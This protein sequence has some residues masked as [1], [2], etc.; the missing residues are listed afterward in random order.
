LS[1][2]G[3]PGPVNGLTDVAGLQVGHWQEDQAPY[4]TGTTVVLAL[5]GAVAGVDVRGG[6]PGTRET[7]ALDPR[8]LVGQAHAVVLTGGSAYGLDAASGVMAWLDERGTG[9]PVGPE[10]GQVVPIVPAAVLFDLGR[11][12]AWSARPDATFGYRAAARASAGPVAAGC[13]G[14]GT[15]AVAGGIKGGSGTASTVLADG[16]VVAAIVAVNA[17]GSGIDPVTGLPWALDHGLEGE[18]GSLL[19]PAEAER[20]EL[21]AAT[22]EGRQGRTGQHTTIGVVAT[23]ATLTGPEASKLAGVAHDGL[24]RALRPAHGPLDGDTLFA[25]STGRRELGA[26]P[27]TTEPV[28]WGGPRAVRLERVYEA[29]AGCV[30]RAVVHALLAARGAGGVPSYRDLCPSA[31]R[32]GGNGR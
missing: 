31:F 10:A 19:P 4:L 6:A 22:R 13:V 2:A 15:G 24:A 25:L 7:D 14:A 11:G 9:F 12:G 5:E 23:D 20:A 32:R 16:S 29:G 1:P 17:R 18:F 8:S 26:G 30:A 21:A 28:T 27:G 3:G